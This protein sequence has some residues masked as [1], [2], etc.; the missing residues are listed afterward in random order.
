M[1]RPRVLSA[2]IRYLP[3]ASLRP[4]VSRPS[5]EAVIADPSEGPDQIRRTSR[6][7]T[8]RPPFI[9]HLPHLAQAFFLKGGVAHRQDFVHQEDLRLQVGRHRKGQ[10][11]IH[12]GG[13][14]L[15]RGV[16]E[17][18]HLGEGDDLVELPVDLRLFHPQ[19]GAVQIDVFPAGEFGMKAGAHFQEGAHPAVDFRP[20]PRWAR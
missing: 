16:Q 4:L 9:G 1:A 18:L 3:Q 11:D 10:A 5:H 8:A 15:H 19:D 20:G 2:S 14:A 7:S 13:I 6:P 17:L 12:A